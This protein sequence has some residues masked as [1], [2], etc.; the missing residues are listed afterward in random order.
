M[1][2]PLFPIFK[3]FYFQFCMV[4]VELFYKVIS[5][6]HRVS[7]RFYDFS[8]FYEFYWLLCEF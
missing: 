4:V 6:F 7:L 2:P 8:T 1:D 5:K 3:L